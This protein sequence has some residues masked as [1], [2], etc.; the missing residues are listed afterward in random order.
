MNAKL[1]MRVLEQVNRGEKEIKVE[2]GDLDETSIELK[3]MYPGS[4]IEKRIDGWYLII[5]DS[6]LK[7]KL[8]NDAS[9]FTN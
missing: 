3:K 7:A 1:M 9:I 4:K 6:I 2:G 8:K 5:E